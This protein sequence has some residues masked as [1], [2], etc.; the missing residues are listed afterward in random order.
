M[1]LEIVP[2]RP[3]SGEQLA[4]LRRGVVIGDEQLT[5]PAQVK[6]TAGK[7]YMV[8]H[9]G[10]KRQIRRMFQAVGLK[11]AILKRIRENK[12]ELGDLLPGKMR[13][14]KREDIV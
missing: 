12:L 8:I 2:N 13:F 6:F 3:P 11:V 5:S 9:E 1:P 14:V 10:K 7:V 4:K